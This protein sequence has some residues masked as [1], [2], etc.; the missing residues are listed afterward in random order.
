FDAPAHGLSDGLHCSLPEF[1]DA[2]RALAAHYGTPSGIVAHSLGAAATAVAFR[3]GL[4][5]TRAVFLAPPADC[6][7][8][9]ERFASFLSLSEPV[10]EAMK[11]RLKSRYRFEW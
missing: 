11:R 5:S 4:A 2:I 3:G 9:S 10:R 7:K 6:E 8:Y 1:V